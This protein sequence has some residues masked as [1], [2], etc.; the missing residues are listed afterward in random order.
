MKILCDRSKVTEFVLE[1]DFSFN[2]KPLYA[3]VRRLKFSES[4]VPVMKPIYTRLIRR[5][6]VLKG[7]AWEI[8]AAYLF[9]CTELNDEIDFTLRFSR[10]PD[11][12]G[13]HC[14]RPS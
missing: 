12:P 2:L 14:S 6:E 3:F 13:R 9:S 1:H 10:S 11:T 7:I 5:A 8:H 4:N